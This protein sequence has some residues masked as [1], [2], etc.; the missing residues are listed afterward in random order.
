M[1]ARSC[2]TER[3]PCPPPPPLCMTLANRYSFVDSPMM[4]VSGQ[5][6]RFEEE[7][8]WI[9]KAPDVEEVHDFLVNLFAQLLLSSE[10]SVVRNAVVQYGYIHPRF[11]P[12]SIEGRQ[13]CSEEGGRSGFTRYVTVEI[14]ALEWQ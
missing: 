1:E 7:I 11:S 12:F 13:V 10:C 8:P 5:V 14:S 6:F 9:S 4:A 2:A 3:K